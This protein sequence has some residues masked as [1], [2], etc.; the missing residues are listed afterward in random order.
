MS[1]AQ[2]CQIVDSHA[3]QDQSALPALRR[4][5]RTLSERQKSI[6]DIESREGIPQEIGPGIDKSFEQ[7][8]QGALAQALSGAI[9]IAAVGEYDQGHLRSRTVHAA[10]RL[11]RVGMR[12]RWVDENDFW[13]YDFERGQSTSES[14]RQ[15]LIPDLLGTPVQL[16]QRRSGLSGISFRK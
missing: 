3:Q 14:W 4:F 9:L 12:E 1:C 6:A 10:Y 5:Y 7:I 16:A 13:I 11:Q 8:I 15:L 2:R